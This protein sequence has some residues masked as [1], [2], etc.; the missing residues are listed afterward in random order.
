MLCFCV[1]AFFSGAT[2]IAVIVVVVAVIVGIVLLIVFLKKRKQRQQSQQG[3]GAD[4]AKLALMA[5]PQGR[6]AA[7]VGIL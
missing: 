1:K 4:V 7:A 3:G 5:T 6:A 2:G